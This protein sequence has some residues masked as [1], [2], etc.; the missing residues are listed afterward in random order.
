[1]K[2]KN[3][4]AT[5]LALN[6][7]VE[8]EAAGH[9]KP[10]YGEI[11]KLNDE[12]PNVAVNHAGFDPG[13]EVM[14][15]A[16]ANLLFSAHAAGEYPKE[17]TYTRKDTLFV[18][19]LMEKVPGGRPALLE[20]LYDLFPQAVFCTEHLF[21]LHRQMQRY[22]TLPVEERPEPLRNAKTD[23]WMYPM[24]RIEALRVQAVDLWKAEEEEHSV[25][26]NR[27]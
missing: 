3:P 13:P 25:D 26:E 21:F 9:Y 1:M 4:I 16:V 27:K 20:V 19:K 14:E 5:I 24:A 2:K 11:L 6:D 7:L 15:Y 17:P 8:S 23:D 10:V 22:F 12:F 18:V